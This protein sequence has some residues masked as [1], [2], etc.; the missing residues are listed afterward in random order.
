MKKKLLLISESVGGGLR[1]HIVQ[2]LTNLDTDIFEVYFIHGTNSLDKSFEQNYKILSEKVNLIPC[3]HLH[4]EISLQND[5]KSLKFIMKKIKEID[6]HIVHCHSSKAGAVGRI[7]AKICGVDKI[8]YTPHAYS[9]FAPEFSKN[10]KRLFVIIEKILSRLATTKTFC[11]SENERKAAINYNIDHE[12]KIICIYNGLEKVSFPTNKKIRK[13]LNIQENRILIGTCARVSEQKNPS[14]FVEIAKNITQKNGNIEFLWCGDGPLL[15]NIKEKVSKL[16]LEKKIHFLGD[17]SD[18]ELIVS[19]FDFFLTTSLYEGLPYAPIEAVRAGV[20]VIASN[21]VGNNEI[22]TS[23]DIGILFDLE[24]S[25]IDEIVLSQVSKIYDKTKIIK[26]FDEKFSLDTMI[27][28]ITN[29]YL[30]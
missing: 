8:F 22:V 17:R 29:E 10:K 28:K 4:R 2:L 20:P 25:S 7:A 18:S 14:L 19:T 9:F 6:P 5:L 24:D 13:S 23:S 21:V 1:K 16:K 12:F 11:V 30:R 15:K 27:K 26:Y 3:E